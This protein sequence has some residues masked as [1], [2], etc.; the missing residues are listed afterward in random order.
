MWQISEWAHN[1]AERVKCELT[2][3]IVLHYPWKDSEIPKSS[4]PGTFGK[5]ARFLDSDNSHIKSLSF[6]SCYNF[7]RFWKIQTP[8]T[9]IGTSGISILPP[10]GQC[11]TEEYRNFTNGVRWAFIIICNRLGDLVWS[12]GSKDGLILYLGA[13]FRTNRLLHSITAKRKTKV[14]AEKSIVTP[15]TS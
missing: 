3:N 2:G 15:D 14:K 6:G 5:I 13:F 7:Y 10:C 4:N 1:V 11:N 9:T 8:E 12:Q